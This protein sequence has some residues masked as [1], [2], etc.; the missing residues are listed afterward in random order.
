MAR[1]AS[2]LIYYEF[3]AKFLGLTDNREFLS[4]GDLK[5]CQNALLANQHTKQ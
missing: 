5:L 2:I 4:S 3:A 1:P